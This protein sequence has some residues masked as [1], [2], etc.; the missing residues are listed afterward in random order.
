M[1]L[2]TTD[3]RLNHPGSGY[4]INVTEKATT[5]AAPTRGAAQHGANLPA[6]L[7][8]ISATVK[9]AMLTPPHEVAAP[10]TEQ[11]AADPNR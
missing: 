3:S 11:R 5:L 10:A 4:A 9:H 6:P 8:P 2:A 1:A 7:C